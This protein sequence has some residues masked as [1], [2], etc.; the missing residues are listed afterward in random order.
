MEETKKIKTE[1][2]KDKSSANSPE[3]ITT[4][5]RKSVDRI[6][7]NIMLLLFI[8][9]AISI[10]FCIYLMAK[11]LNMEKQI[12]QL[13]AEL[14]A[15]KQGTVVY[16]DA[17]TDGILE[18][19]LLALDYDATDDIGKNNSEE[20]TYL[21]AT[22]EGGNVSE[23]ASTES[24]GEINRKSNG[25]KVYLTFDDGP[26]IYTDE[27]LAILEEKNVKA[28]FFVVYNEDEE[29]WDEYNKIVEGGHTL[30]MHSYSH[31]Y[32]VVYANKESFEEDVTNIHD[33]LYEQTGIDCTYYRFPGGSSNTVTE[34]DIKTRIGYLNE[35]GYTYFD[36]NSLS[37]DAVDVTLTPEQL[38]ENIMSYV[39][40]NQGDSIVLMHDLK[41]N[42]ATVE[43]LA[44]LIDTLKEEG[45]EICPIDEN[46]QP[47]QHVSY[48]LED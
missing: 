19:D 16:A 22:G 36:W 5:N 30:G 12:D 3:E 11:M 39:R 17:D 42:H 10:V 35:E 14:D 45:Y 2:E 27:I 31:V 40:C 9:S 1:N 26:S 4:Y 20:N 37:G 43:G 25:K 41:N 13:N 28:T 29:L 24:T 21:G 38:N 34:V 23:N 6:K 7:R 32:D 8:V 33:F 18:D 46:T 15:R 47:V 48:K 44:D